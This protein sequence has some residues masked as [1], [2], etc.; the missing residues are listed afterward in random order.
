[1]PILAR[2]L[3]LSVTWGSQMSLQRLLWGLNVL[4]TA[5]YKYKFLIRLPLWGFSL[6]GGEDA[7]FESVKKCQSNGRGWVLA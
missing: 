7:S 6:L 2:T 4:H 5:H 3:F 1:M